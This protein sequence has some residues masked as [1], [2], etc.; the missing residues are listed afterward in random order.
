M[1]EKKK[2]NNTYY[3][4]AGIIVLIVIITIV[5]NTQT[6]P[7][8]TADAATTTCIAESSVFY[9]A[10]WCGYCQ[11]Q[12]EMFGDNAKLLNYIECEEDREACALAEI[13]IYPTWDIEGERYTGLQS[14][15]K[16]KE[17]TGC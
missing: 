12:K 6:E 7:A 4:V 15:E 9:G 11:R 16:L 13:K 10:E 1:E 17:L 5:L 8:P 14:V 2:S 3:I